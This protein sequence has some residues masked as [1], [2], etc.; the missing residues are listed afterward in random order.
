[1][2]RWLSSVKHWF[3]PHKQNDH[4]PHLI[5]G[6]GLAVVVVLIF[7]LNVV[8]L[9]ARPAGLAPALSGNV[10]AY[11][12][13][14]TPVALFN[15]TNQERA[16]A[17]LPPLRLDSRLNQSAS[18]K[19]QNMFAENYWAHVSPSGIQPWHWFTQ[20]GYNYQY[21]GE[22]LAKDFDTSAG[23]MDGWMNSAGHRANVLNAHYTDVGFA[24]VNGTLV[25]GETTLVVAH[26]GSPVAVAGPAATPKPPT[27]TPATPRRP[28]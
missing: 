19:A 18:L 14:I 3:V 23:V 26:Y 22:N 4:R 24:V 27:P 7:G 6:H 17:G 12:V 20:A 1:M 21:A 5:R 13:D 16:N 25:G 8:G 28:W 11:A 10:L 9:L 2:M 15:L